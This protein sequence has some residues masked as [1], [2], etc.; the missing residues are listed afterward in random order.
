MSVSLL[1]THTLPFEYEI[2]RSGRRRSISIEVSKAKVV[3]RSPLFVANAQ[4]EKFVNEKSGWVQQKLTQQQYQIDEVPQRTYA[5]GSQ[6]PLMDCTLTLKVNHQTQA[7]IFRYGDEL[8]IYLASR[9]RLSDED[10]ARRLVG[11]WYQRQA[12][13]VLTTKTDSAARAIGANHI[14]VTIKA[15]RSKWGHCTVRGA[16]QYNWQIL[17]A[18][19]PIVDYLVAHEVSHLLHHNHSPDFWQIV[20]SICPEYKARR[21]W[22]KAHGIQLVL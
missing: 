21:A 22:L 15:T 4:L 8:R 5:S 11:Q 7:D 17:L 19:E 3:V 2:V 1:K 18:P 9:S 20:A 16:I 12:L 14:G 6:L 10:Q 13:N